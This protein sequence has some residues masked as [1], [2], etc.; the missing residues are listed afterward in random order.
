MIDIEPRV[1]PVSDRVYR[2]VSEFLFQ[3]ARLLDDSRYKEWLGMLDPKIHY[4]LV[5]PTL[6]LAGANQPSCGAT[7]LD[8]TFDSFKARVQQLTTPGFTVAENPRPFTRRFV[9][10]ISI[11]PASDDGPLQVQS[12][13]LVYRSRGSQMQPHL[14]SMSRHDVLHRVA[15]E[16]RLLKRDAQLDESVVTARSITGL[17]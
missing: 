12:N 15:G 13:A 10:N 6:A 8:E 9:A 5:T 2:E 16:L 4:R 1:L 3:E 11:E 14:F 7:L 17:W